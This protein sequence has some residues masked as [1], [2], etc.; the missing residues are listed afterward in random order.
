[1]RFR[2]GD[3]FEIPL[4]DKRY[5]YAQYLHK[6]KKYIHLIKIFDYFTNNNKPNLENIKLSKPL[7]LPVFTSLGH[8]V[9]DENWGIIGNLP[10]ENFIFPKFLNTI[11]YFT[12]KAGVWYL[13]DGEKEISLGRELPEEYK[14]L[15]FASLYAPDL[16]VQRIMTGEK[17]LDDLIKTN[18]T[19]NPNPNV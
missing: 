14:N 13:Y 5:A 2:V 12:G 4:P 1:M 7:F 16:I 15:E 6:D 8:A 11:Y 17:P 18:R 3:I 19:T 9:K 10:V